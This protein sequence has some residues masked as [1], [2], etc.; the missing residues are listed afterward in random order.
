MGTVLDSLDI[1]TSAS[2]FYVCQSGRKSVGGTGRSRSGRSHTRSS[3][4]THVSS[5]QHVWIIDDVQKTRRHPKR[6]SASNRPERQE[7]TSRE[8]P[9]ARLRPWLSRRAASGAHTHTHTHRL[10]PASLCVFDASDCEWIPT[11]LLSLPPPP[12]WW[13]A[14]C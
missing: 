5:A 11:E 6:K 4:W 3:R 8:A 14:R 13:L 10:V 9:A 7:V 1:V 12:G 2:F